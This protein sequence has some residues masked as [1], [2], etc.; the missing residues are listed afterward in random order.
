[1]R[2][3]VIA[4]EPADRA[5]QRRLAA[6]GRPDEHHELAVLDR[7]VD[8][9]HGADTSEEFLGD[10]LEDDLPHGAVTVRHRARECNRCHTRWG[11]G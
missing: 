3:A 8:V 11:E 5:E 2:P 1:M 10:A 9:I 6:A 7:Q 4:L